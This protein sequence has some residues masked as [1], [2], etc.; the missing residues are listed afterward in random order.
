MSHFQL[1]LRV[2]I[3]LKLSDHLIALLLVPLSRTDF[4]KAQSWSPEFECVNNYS[5][6]QLGTGEVPRNPQMSRGSL[7]T[8]CTFLLYFDR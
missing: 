6:A 7:W 2:Y 3:C 4:T 8:E 1:G 5:K